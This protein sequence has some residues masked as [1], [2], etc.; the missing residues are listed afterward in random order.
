MT[1]SPYVLES[2]MQSINYVRNICAHH[3]RLWNRTLT[4]RPELPQKTENGWL[5]NKDIDSAKLYAFLSCVV[6]L[7]KVINHKTRFGQH[8]RELI[9][10]YPSVNLDSMGFHEEW[11][12]EDLW[13]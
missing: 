2:W 13:A 9:E 12:T 7:V 6:Y 10:K 1:P 5:K 8:F 4:I 11:R 3:S